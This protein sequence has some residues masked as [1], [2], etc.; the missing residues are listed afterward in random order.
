MN[1]V[2]QEVCYS[3]LI[4]NLARG[5]LYFF[6]QGQLGLMAFPPYFSVYMVNTVTVAAST[7]FLPYCPISQ[8]R[9]HMLAASCDIPAWISTP[10]YPDALNTLK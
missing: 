8:S 2:F 4:N 7:Y 10:C 5:D 9:A 6:L 3:Q 1:S